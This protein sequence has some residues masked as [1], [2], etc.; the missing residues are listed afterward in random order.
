MSTKFLIRL[1]NGL[2]FTSMQKPEETTHS[3]SFNDKYGLYKSFPI[4][5]KDSVE[6]VEDDDDKHNKRY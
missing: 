3:I 1:K 4:E 5:Q 2:I 6:E